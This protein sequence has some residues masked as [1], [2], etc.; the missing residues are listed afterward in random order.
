VQIG[1]KI[2]QLRLSKL[3]T[4]AD[5]AGAQITRN[6]LSSIE[7]G[8]A[9]PSLPTAMYI[10]ERLNVP[11]GYLLSD[12]DQEFFYR[13]MM[14][15]ANIRHAFE[16]HDYAGCL[17]LLLALGEEQD[18]ELFLLRA[19]CE[20]GIAKHAFE[21]GRLRFAAIALD[22]ALG[23]MDKTVYDTA[24]L[25]ERVAVCFRYMISVSSTLVSD[26][27]DNTEIENARA[28]GDPLVEYAMAIEA[29]EGD[30]AKSA[31][32]FI[33]RHPD[34]LYAIRLS[35]LLL[36]KKGEYKEAQGILES[37]LNRDELTFGVLLYEVFGDLELC[38]RKNDDY[39]KAYE[40]SV[41]RIGI[42]EKML[43]EV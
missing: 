12:E 9:L 21:Q 5:L 19:E 34:S 2:K 10:A 33:A 20:Y 27:L 13:K 14:S 1:E 24:W 29:L 3:M 40:F 39:K 17:S 16:A 7:H 8:T 41:S 37:L 28:L 18:D 11:V 32:E 22:R 35:A 6:M 30:R 25:R 36:M 4:Q 42:L 31:Q 43:E 15:M 23:A 38:Y 26:I